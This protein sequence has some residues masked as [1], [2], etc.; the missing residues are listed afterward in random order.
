[1]IPEGHCDT[2]F[3]FCKDLNTILTVDR[4]LKQ[5]TSEGPSYFLKPSNLSLCLLAMGKFV[6]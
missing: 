3:S 4:E 2:P 5:E 1:M 6:I